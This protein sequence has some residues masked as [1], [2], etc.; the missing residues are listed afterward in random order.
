MNTVIEIAPRLGPKATCEAFGVSRATYY[1]K[2]MPMHGPWPRRPTPARRISDHERKV[3][4]DVLQ[5]ERFADV[6]P[7]EVHATLLDEGQFLCSVRSMHRILAECFEVRDRRN[8]LRHPNHARPE[9]LATRPNELWSW[10]ITKLKG[11]RKWTY[12]QLYVVLD[13]FSRYVVGWMVAHRESA[14]LAKKLFQETCRRHGIEPGQLTIHADRGSS[15]TSKPV[16]LLM[17]DMGITKTHSRPHVSNDNPYSEAQFK[18]TKYRPDFPKT[19]NNIEHARSFLGD[20]V[21]W[22]NDEHHHSGLEMHTP[23]DVHF[24]RADQRTQERQQVLDKAFESRPERF[25]HGRPLAKL[26]PSAVWI[27]KPELQAA[28]TSLPTT[29]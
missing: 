13:V 12:F 22:Y 23:A 16:A 27:N 18:T 14:R 8:Q 17:S 9:L 21:A 29:H 19:F 10:D 1:R 7:A 28:P 4:L 20:F 24:G 26:P 5:E 25:P 11:P 3:V 15:M 6:A 2:R